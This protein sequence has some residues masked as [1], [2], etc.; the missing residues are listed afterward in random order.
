MAYIYG[1]V[2]TVRYGKSQIE[3]DAL[4]A[5]V[6]LAASNFRALFP[7]DN[8]PEVGIRFRNNERHS[9]F[10]SLQTELLIPTI[11]QSRKLFWHFIM[12]R[13]FLQS[14]MC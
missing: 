5:K 2:R 12:A 4:L 13:S 14:M 7:S 1:P 9:E 6:T 8:E 10:Q 11:E 3:L